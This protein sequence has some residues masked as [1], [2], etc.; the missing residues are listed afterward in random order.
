MTVDIP[1]SECDLSRCRAQLLSPA[2]VIEISYL[3]SLITKLPLELTAANIYAL[4]TRTTTSGSLWQLR[5]IGTSSLTSLRKRLSQH[6]FKCTAG[7]NS[8]LSA[9][10]TARNENDA[11]G[12]S[13]LHVNPNEMRWAVEAILIKE[14]NPDWNTHGTIRMAS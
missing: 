5:Y 7:T 4:W 2:N 9:V 3:D 8:K 12:V 13:L 14:R 1:L 11:I 6:L 10:Q